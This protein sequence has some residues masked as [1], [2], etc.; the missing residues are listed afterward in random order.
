MKRALVIGIGSPIISD[1]AIGIR[2]AE[3]V[4]KLDLPDVD[5]EEASVSGLD[6]IEKMLDHEP[7]VIVDAIVTKELEPGTVVVLSPDVFSSSVHG[8]NPHETNIATAMEL[9]R[10]LEP[11]RFPK[12]IF[13]VAVEALNTID[14]SEEMTPPVKAALPVAVKKVRELLER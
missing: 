10:R 3:E 6:M 4:M 9:G 13:F 14:I 2:V 12:E 7:V 11:E 1:D 5:V 8:T